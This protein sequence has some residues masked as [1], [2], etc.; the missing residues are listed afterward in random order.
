MLSLDV[1]KLLAGFREQAHLD[2]K[3]VTKY[4]GW[5]ST[6][7]RGH[8]LGHWLTAMSIYVSQSDD[9]DAAA[10]IEYA[11]HSLREC[12]NAIGTGFLAAWDERMLD[13]VEDTGQGWAPYYTVHKIL[14]GLIDNYNYTGNAEALASAKSLGDYL[15]L[16]A[17]YIK[18]RNAGKDNHSFIER[19]GRHARVSWEQA[20][21]IQETGGYSEAMLNLYALTGNESYLETARLFHQMNKLEPASRGIDELHTGSEHNHHHA[22]TT[23]PQF[24]A[25]A[26]DAQLTGDE[27][28]LTSA[29]NFWDMVVNHRTYNIGSTGNHEHWNLPADRIIDELTSQAGE[30][31]ATYNM[32]RLSNLL[33]SMEP[34]AQYAEYVERA[35]CNHILSSIQPGTSNFMYFH[36]VKPGTPRTYGQNKECFWCCTGTGMENP[37]RYAESIYFED[38]EHNR[39]YINQFI[40]STMEGVVKLESNFPESDEATL[41]L[42]CDTTMQIY[43]RKPSW[44]SRFK[45]KGAKG[46]LADGYV[47]LERKWKKGDKI[48]ISFPM[49]DHNE[50]V[51]GSNEV[52][53]I[54]HGPLVMAAKTDDTQLQQ[55]EVT[56]T[57]NFFNK[58][59]AEY[60]SN[61]DIP[62]FNASQTLTPLYK[63]GNYRY[64]VYWKTNAAGVTP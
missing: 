36:T 37:V 18:Q 28:K 6:D 21:E 24:I 10:R 9:K 51:L 1:D 22:N 5:E 13:I 52:Y 63:L 56:V 40:G 54:L 16:R 46:K 57:D 17:D 34:R 45:I 44:S 26:R 19:Q 12:Q 2:T 25:A 58:V 33:F 53:S 30:T 11:V 60:D 20:L 23:I 27:K 31:C 35:L 7:L 29:R 4:G 59:P 32:I 55:E 62:S 14:Q 43:I 15:A 48:R 42:L 64:T 50:Y 3:G 47:T 39:L 38:L 61:M 8:T 41:T 49:D